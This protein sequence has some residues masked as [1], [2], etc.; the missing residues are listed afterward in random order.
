MISRR[1]LIYSIKQKKSFLCVGLDTDISKI[2]DFLKDYPDPVFEFNKQIIDATSDLC[3]AYKPNA[4]FYESRGVAGWQSLVKTW[5]H[6]PEDCLN[7]ID[8]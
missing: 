5:N 7:I 4:A 8:A 3:V 1:D 2:P 6:L